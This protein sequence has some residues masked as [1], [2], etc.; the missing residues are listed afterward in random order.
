MKHHKHHKR[1]KGASKTNDKQPKKCNQKDDDNDS[2]NEKGGELPHKTE[3]MSHESSDDNLVKIQK[4]KNQDVDSTDSDGIP[5]DDSENISA[6]DPETI[7]MG[8]EKKPIQFVLWILRKV[9]QIC[10]P[11]LDLYD[12]FIPTYR[13]ETVNVLLD[14]YLEEK[15]KETQQQV[16]ED[17]QNLN[18]LL[19]DLNSMFNLSLSEIQSNSSSND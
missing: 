6:S 15:S 8:K 17:I 3:T 10:D 7:H 18:S 5:T 11:N 9:D 12:D 16:G 13:I 4:T 19:N 1:K 14:K 2:E